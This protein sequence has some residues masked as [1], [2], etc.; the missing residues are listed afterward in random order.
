MPNFVIKDPEKERREQ[1]QHEKEVALREQQAQA[2]R[3]QALRD[4]EEQERIMAERMRKIENQVQASDSKRSQKV[5]QYRRSS[6]RRKVFAT[7]IL[8]FLTIGLLVFGTYNTFFKQG[9]TN[10]EIKALA[11]DVVG[12]RIPEAGVEGYLKQ[13]VNALIK[14]NSTISAAYSSPVESFEVDVNTLYVTF[15]KPRATNYA[16]VYFKA[17][18]VIKEQDSKD[19]EGNIVIGETFRPWYSFYLP[20]YYDNSTDGI[21]SAGNLEILAWEI[22]NSIDTIENPLL[23]FRQTASDGSIV[24]FERMDEKTTENARRFIENF[25]VDFYNNGKTVTDLPFSS[26]DVR[27]LNNENALT[28]NSISEF[29]FYTKDNYEGFNVYCT[30]RLTSPEGLSILNTSYFKLVTNGN[31]WLISKMR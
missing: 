24:E 16:N 31:S 22:E 27:H 20:V 3:A 26:P 5:Q 30:Y 14:K 23:N 1:E 25:L 13:N 4:Q 9:I 11:R 21:V 7:L 19:E 8:I 2:A 28:F 6:R 29:A 12:P 15:I 18:M 17:Q 10:D